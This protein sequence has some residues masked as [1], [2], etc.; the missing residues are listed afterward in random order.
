MLRD[1]YQVK[2]ARRAKPK[3]PVAA[4]AVMAPNVD[5]D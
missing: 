2:Y 5:K 4:D 1:S 3:K